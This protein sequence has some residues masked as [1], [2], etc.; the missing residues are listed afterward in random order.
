MVFEGVEII[1]ESMLSYEAG[2]CETVVL[3]C[4]A[5]NHE[6]IT[7]SRLTAHESDQIP[8]EIN[9]IDGRIIAVSETGLQLVIHEAKLSDNGTYFCVASNTVSNEEIIAYLN[10]TTGNVILI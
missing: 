3:N 4:T 2:L 5:F 7:W 1:T 10:I 9:S 6:S 8:K